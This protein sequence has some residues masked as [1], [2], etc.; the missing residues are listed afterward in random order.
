MKG[1]IFVDS[2]WLKRKYLVEKLSCPEIADLLGNVSRQ[3]VF[4]HLKGLGIRIRSKKDAL[5]SKDGEQC[6]FFLGYVWIYNPSHPRAYHNY[7]KRATVHL[8]KKLGRYL[9]EGEFAHHGDGNRLN[10]HPDNLELSNLHEHP[11]LHKLMKAKTRQ[12]KLSLGP[13]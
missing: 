6:K 4:K 2:E 1:K 8:E 9:E 3:G 12:L 13:T 10:D 11:G 5:F 7:V